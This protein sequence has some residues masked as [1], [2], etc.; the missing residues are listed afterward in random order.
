MSISTFHKYIAVY[1]YEY[2]TD[3]SLH[4]TPTTENVLL[5]MTPSKR[6]AFTLTSTTKNI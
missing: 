3:K 4:V 1:I 5:Y 2:K 6:N